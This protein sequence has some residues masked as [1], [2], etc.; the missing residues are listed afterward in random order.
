MA[1]VRLFKSVYFQFSTF[2]FGIPIFFNSENAFFLSSIK[3]GNLKKTRQNFLELDYYALENLSKPLF[4]ISFAS[5][6]PP[7]STIHPLIN[8]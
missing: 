6:G 2:L 1:L 8:T 7:D 3:E 5:S 4:S